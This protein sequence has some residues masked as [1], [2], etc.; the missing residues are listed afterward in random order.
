MEDVTNTAPSAAPETSAPISDSVPAHAAPTPSALSTTARQSRGRNGSRKSTPPQTTDE[1]FSASME[2]VFDKAS[3]NVQQPTD[4]LTASTD[5]A[6]APPQAPNSLGDRLDLELWASTPR[7]VQEL[8]LARER[9]SAQKIS[10][11]G[12]ELAELKKAGGA[13]AEM[14]GVLQKYA[15]RIPNAPDGRPMAPATVLETL[16]QA[17]DALESNPMSAIAY[18]AQSYGVSLAA[19]AHDP[20]AAGAQQQVVAHHQREVQ[21]LR[22]QL[23][24][25]QAQHEQFQRQRFNYVHHQTLQFF[26]GKEYSPDLEQEIHHQVAALRDRN[27]ALFQADPMAVLR[28]AE[29]RA[30][31]FTGH[32][33][34]SAADEAR[35]KAA[36]AKRL[37]SLN[38]KSVV[39][40]SPSG[41]SKDIWSN[42]N[43]GAAYDRATRR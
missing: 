10:E 8:L 21:Q 15:G 37:A 27:P 3:G 38:V 35:K 26:E 28:E 9:E 11:Q 18:L 42:D 25:M 36:E 43:W 6:Q 12:R 22:Q 32:G 34:K 1:K 2:Q 33:D 16:L 30:L 40:K 29:K 23:A 19:L 20:E 24:Q 4:P 41:I 39:G 13:A 31:K 17:H 14:G 7:Q 5:P